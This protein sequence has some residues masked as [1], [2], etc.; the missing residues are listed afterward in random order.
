VRL[1]LPVKGEKRYIKL[2]LIKKY[3]QGK[4]MQIGIIS[5]SH[6][7]FKNVK[8]AVTIFKKNKINFVIHL[9]DFIS[10]P[11]VKLFKGLNLI[12]VFGNND[13]NR[14]GFINEFNKINGTLLGDFGIIT[15][16]GVR[17]ALYHG[18]YKEISE[19]LVK[20]GDYDIILTGHFHRFNKI[21]YGKSQWISIGSS[22]DS[23]SKDNHPSIG[24]LNTK[25]KGVQ[26]IEI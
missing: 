21:Q 14:I 11:I 9:G 15:L 16:D 10:V 4:K 26:F 20:C 6:D 12:G 18:E 24:I 5:D 2:S 19:A 23:L 25:S 17:I 8:K 13:G 7:D 3:S 1:L 22:H